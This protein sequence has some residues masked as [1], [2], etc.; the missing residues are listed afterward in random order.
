MPGLFYNPTSESFSRAELRVGEV[1]LS[2]SG[3]IEK[4]GHIPNFQ[5]LSRPV[6]D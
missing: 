1:K 5:L 3:S 4:K 6:L 2:R